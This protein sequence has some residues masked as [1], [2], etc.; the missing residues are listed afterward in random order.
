MPWD[1][2]SKERALAPVHQS[3]PAARANAGQITKA[4]DNAIA[5]LMRAGHRSRVTSVS[6]SDNGDFVASSDWNGDVKIWNASD[7]REVQSLALNS[8]WESLVAISP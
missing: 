8:G 6:L 4:A 5:F 1:D 7:G 2:P 3:I